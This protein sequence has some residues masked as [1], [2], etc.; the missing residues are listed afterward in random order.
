MLDPNSRRPQNTWTREE[1]VILCLLYRF[2]HKD[3]HAFKEVFNSIFRDELSQCGLE[4]GL[5]YRVLNTQWEDMKR[6]GNPIWH[7]V[8][9]QSAFNRH[10]VY[11]KRLQKI[12]I[13]AD[14]LGLTL[15]PK[16]HDDIDITTFVLKFPRS[17]SSVCSIK[18]Q[19]VGCRYAN[20]D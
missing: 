12:E 11:S 4:T 8:H 16:D 1:R 17:N 6:H 13:T 5:L 19:I 2:Y 10:G 9:I 20:L 15:E 14:L 3:Y 7:E 18:L